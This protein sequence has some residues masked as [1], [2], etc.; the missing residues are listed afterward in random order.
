MDNTPSIRSKASG[1]FFLPIFVLLGVAWLFQS[2][3]F[4]GF[5][6]FNDDSRYVQAAIGWLNG[7]PY[8]GETHWAIRHSLVISMAVSFAVF[9]VGQFAI[10]IPS[11]LCYL[12]LQVVTFCAVRSAFS[13]T[14][15][16]FCVLMV[17]IIPI[18]A[19]NAD[20]VFV[21]PYELFLIV[22]SFFLFW[23]SGTRDR[24]VVYAVLAGVLAGLA[25]L[26]RETTG[27]YLCGLG[28]LFLLGLG[29]DRKNYFLMAGGFL[30]VVGLDAAYFFFTA[31]DW[32]YRL[33][34]SSNHGIFTAAMHAETYVDPKS[35]DVKL[36]FSNYELPLQV[37]ELLERERANSGDRYLEYALIDVGRALSPYLMLWVHYYFGLTYWLG[38]V[39]ALYVNKIR[40]NL[41][42]SDYHRLLPVAILIIGVTW[43]LAGTYLLNL[44]PHPRYWAVSTFA[45][46]VLGGLWLAWIWSLGRRILAV[47]TVG[48]VFIGHLF[49]VEM[50]D[51]SLVYARWL[52]DYVKEKQKV[53]HLPRDNWKSAEVYFTV[54]EDVGNL[55]KPLPDPA[56]QRI[57]VDDDAELP[58]PIA[59]SP[60]AWCR[61]WE[62]KSR[63]TWMGQ[64]FDIV[65]VLKFIPAK[66]R[67]PLMVPEANLSIYERRRC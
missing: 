14:A 63:A 1:T 26:T 42:A 49:L 59:N 34:I 62:K 35:L 40:H 8:V 18:S 5:E 27:A 15:A 28:I 47:I 46:A 60:S 65:G 37:K 24:S 17:A 7:F 66:F 12:G 55:V 30:I 9:G 52:S 23:F 54:I 33:R 20:A 13:T 25:F 21:W 57:L 67:Q 11:L 51:S 16:V 3:T 61:I 38:T 10:T 19:V 53:V 64:L 31:G 2:A 32:L 41:A 29:P 48:L 6:G 4:I 56:A 50:N 36:P 45:A 44:R 58:E 43:F 22:C 39:G